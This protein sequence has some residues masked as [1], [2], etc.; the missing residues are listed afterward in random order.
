[1]LVLFFRIRISYLGK[2]T[3][4][5]AAKSDK[6]IPTTPTIGAMFERIVIN[7]TSIGVIEEG[8]RS[9]LRPLRRLHYRHA[10]GII[11][12]IDSN[13]RERID[14]VRDE[15]HQIFNDENLQHKSIL[16]LANKQ[17]LPDAIK[18]DE[19]RDKLNLNKF[20]GNIKWHLQPTSA[21][22]N[23]GVYEGFEWLENSL[24]EKIDP[25][26]P[27]VEIIND[28]KTMHNY[29]KSIF[30]INNFKTFLNKLI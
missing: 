24:K 27:I 1:M 26:K 18:V 21:I 19:L 6:S 9:G 8:G 15:L 5:Y 16:I 4:L 22:H 13:D 10:E 14:Q 25:I 17:D 11:F 23:E 3:V 7:N 29:L 12:V 2:T 28:A 20:N 30:N